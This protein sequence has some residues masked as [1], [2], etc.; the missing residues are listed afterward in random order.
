[1]KL[2]KYQ[3][4]CL[5]AIPESGRVAICMATGLGKTVTF[6]QIPRKGRMLIIAHREE[7]LE[8]P[9]KYFN[10]SYGIEKGSLKS[11]GEDV[12]AASIQTLVRRLDKFKT[13]DF[14][15]I[16]VDEFHHAAAQTYKK[17]LEYFKPRLLVGVSATPKRS[18]GNKLDDIFDE[19]IY[20]KDLLSGISDGY[21]S[22]ISCLSIDV[23]FNL[24]QVK[25]KMGDLDSAQLDKEMIG[26]KI[27]EAVAETYKKYAIGQ[28]VI[29]GCSIKHCELI[30]ERIPGS[31]I[32]TGKTKDRGKI[33]KDFENK[34]IKCIVNCM[35]LTE[36]TDLPCIET[37]IIARPTKSQSLYIQ[38]VGRGCRKYENKEKLLLIDCVGVTGKHELC[39][40]ATLVGCD[41]SGV[42]NKTDI[43]GDIFELPE[44]ITMLSDVPASWVRNVKIVELFAKQNN[45]SIHNVN[46]FKMPNGALI[47]QLPE[48]Q[49]YKIDVI[50]KTGWTYI[51]S[52]NRSPIKKKA[53]DAFDLIYKTLLSE[54]TENKHIWDLSIA[55]KWGKYPASDKQKTLIKRRCDI[56]VEFLTKLEASHILNRLFNRS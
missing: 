8:Q 39:C 9:R 24:T 52:Y 55:K 27:V 47:C 44:K 41:V 49:W 10:C 48:K 50:D 11:Q 15:V 38:C 16:V 1:M 36:G 42:N 19:I 21:L 17:T 3:E 30:S 34:K 25:T 43:E 33:L 4:D 31:V 7:L 13:D 54:Q 12:I 2:R 18:D 14:D 29:F 23:G 56:D 32:I 28:T 26:L 45:Y 35:V 20:E 22:N 6:S 46:Y 51:S 5:K 37:I 40:A 53:Q